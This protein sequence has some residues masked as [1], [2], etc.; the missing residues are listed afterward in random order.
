MSGTSLDG[1]DVAVIDITRGRIQPLLFRTTPY[2]K[3]VR[4]ALLSVSNTM[5]H[6]ATIARLHFLLG[7]LY[8]QAIRDT[9]RR[10]VPLKSIQLCGLH[11]Q[12][13]FH[14]GSPIEY[15][16][17]RIA[18]TFQIGDAA[19]VAERTGIRT[20][21]NFRERDIAAGGKGAPL[22][23]YVDY[24]LFRDRRKPRVALNIG[25]IANITVIPAAAKPEDVI[26][27]DTGP[28]N[29]ILDAL[30]AK[31]TGGKQ[32]FDRGG[33]IARKGKVHDRLLEG[34][35]RDPHFRMAPPKSA[36]REQ[37]GQEFASGLMATGLPLEDLIAT[38][39]E[40]TA[41]SISLAIATYA[42]PAS[43]V[44]ASGGG[45]H[46]AFLMQRLRQLL[47]AAKLSTSADFGIDPGAKEAIAFAVLAHE[48]NR[49]QPANLPS[50]T[51]A[52]RP[53]VLGRITPA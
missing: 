6:T 12:T 43:E 21:S 14:E 24:M 27:F 7:E 5:T 9:C 22:V 19:V 35:L 4:E 16:G 1:I 29:M 3:A 23:P 52:R 40:L 8:A 15:L 48:S 42:E 18:S 41:R 28:G 45:I 53:V 38:A 17:H 25:G 30:T 39:T 31:L 44:I 50:A 47:P 33:R 46:N 37:F 32:T 49:G 26:A 20:V 10:R 36:G 51:G 34:M 2:P 13:I 11:G